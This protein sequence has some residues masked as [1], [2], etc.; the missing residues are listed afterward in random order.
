MNTCPCGT[1][2]PYD[3]C[4]GLFISGQQLPTTPEALMRSRYT[5]YTQ[6]N[7]DYISNTMK[8]PASKDFNPEEARS[9]AND[10]SWL[11]LEIVDTSY[12]DDHHGKVEFIAHYA[13]ENMKYVLHEVSLFRRDDKQWFYIDGH[14]PLNK[15][16][17][18]AH[19]KISRNDPCS[20]GS[21]KKYKKCCGTN[22]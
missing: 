18:R 7:I 15:P 20:C 21:N 8:E 10:V 9:W 6:A 22:N 4:C 5:A 1:H 2:K 19:K 13:H 16:Q 17:T 12:D 11:K 3:H 14:G